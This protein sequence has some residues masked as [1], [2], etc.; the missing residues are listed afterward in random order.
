M[1]YG[2]A[3][4]LAASLSTTAVAQEYNEIVFNQASE[5]V[6]WCKSEAEARYIARGITPFQ[7]TARYYDRS[8][9]LFVEGKLRADGEDVPVNCRVARGAR[10]RYATVEIDDPRL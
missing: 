8:N 3:L 9:V 2:Y 1:R 6:P 10:E 5:L 7:W 4:I